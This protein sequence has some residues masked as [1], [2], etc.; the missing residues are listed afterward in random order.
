MPAQRYDPFRIGPKDSEELKRKKRKADRTLGETIM[1]IENEGFRS[2]RK[3]SVFIFTCP[4]CKTTVSLSPTMAAFENG[5]WEFAPE[6]ARRRHRAAK[7][8]EA[9]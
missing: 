8:S 1:M 3:K 5:D 6:A 2:A 7:C 9:M 4:K